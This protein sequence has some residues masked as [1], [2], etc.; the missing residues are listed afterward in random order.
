MVLRAST[1]HPIPIMTPT[2]SN[3][4]PGLSV[5]A[6]S[7]SKF[8]FS[9]FCC[10]TEISFIY[11][12]TLRL[13]YRDHGC[14]SLPA[15]RYINLGSEVANLCAIGFGGAISSLFCFTNDILGWTQFCLGYEFQGDCTVHKVTV[16]DPS[17]F[18]IV[19]HYNDKFYSFRTSPGITCDGFV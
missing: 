12:F 18:D 19:G 6:S 13:R 5:S 4:I 15:E 2:L 3:L 1:S 7:E 14:P 16:D 8:F 10:F 17:C 9:F 11:F